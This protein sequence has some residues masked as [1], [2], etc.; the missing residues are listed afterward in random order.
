MCNVK[1]FPAILNIEK[2]D[3]TMK[4]LLLA[5]L[6]GLLVGI[7]FRFLKLPLPAPPVL[8]GIIGIV[9]IY[10]GGV[11]FDWMIRLFQQ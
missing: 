9:G 10:L 7:I 2:E 5:L 6:A 1:L 3:R 8:S 11:L 4:E